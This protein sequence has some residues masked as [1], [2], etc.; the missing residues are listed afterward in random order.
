M[1]HGVQGLLDE[2][3][4][5]LST[6]IHSELDIE[7][8]K[9]T[10]SAFLGSCRF[11]LPEI[12]EDRAIYEKLFEILNKLKL[13]HLFILAAMI[14]WIPLKNYQIMRLLQGRVRNF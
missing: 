11:K 9:R 6:Q 14:L 12:H 3:Y 2:Q 13:I 10:P 4:V 1:L 7:L 8:L 5:D